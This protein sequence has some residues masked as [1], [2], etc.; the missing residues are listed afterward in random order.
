MNGL[1]GRDQIYYMSY[2]AVFKGVF[3]TANQA[4]ARALRGM[5][6]KISLST[7]KSINTSV[8]YKLEL[9]ILRRREAT[10]PVCSAQINRQ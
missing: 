4:P 1:V 5:T 2:N 9:A 6:R 10:Y 7:E 8:L 3:S